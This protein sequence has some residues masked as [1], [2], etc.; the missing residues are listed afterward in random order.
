MLLASLSAWLTYF[1]ICFHP[2]FVRVLLAPL[3]QSFIDIY[4]FEDDKAYIWG[5]I[6]FVLVEFLLCTT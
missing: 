1:G 4:G 5:G 6:G 3:R 2:I